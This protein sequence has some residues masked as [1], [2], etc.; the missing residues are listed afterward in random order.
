VELIVF[1]DL[2]AISFR[3]FSR[4]GDSE[5]NCGENRES[6]RSGAGFERR[7]LDSPRPGLVKEL[8]FGRRR[9]RR[10]DA[11]ANPFRG[12]KLAASR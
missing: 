2:S 12:F 3:R 6:D 4:K 7:D 8:F 10:S 1:K 5:K 11:P 9:V